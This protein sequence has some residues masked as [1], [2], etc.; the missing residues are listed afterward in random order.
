M[1]LL[2]AIIYLAFISLGLPDSLLGS[3]WPVISKDLNIGLAFAGVIS[4]VV[5]AGT[6]VSSLLST[7]V[8]HRFGT[9]IVIVIS[10]AMTAFALYGFTFAQNVWV[11]VILAIPLGLGAGAV[12]AALNNFVA[13]HYKS[14]HMNYL[15]SFW[16]VGATSGPL[17]MAMYLSQQE[18]WRDGYATISYIQ[19]ALVLILFLALPLWKIATN[20][21]QT[22]DGERPHFVSNAMGLRIKGV[23]FQ[24]L[25]FFCYCSLEAATGLWAASFLILEHGVTPSNAAF[26]TAMYFLGI[27][28]G[29]FSC[30]FIADSIDEKKMISVGVVL[31]FIGVILLLMPLSAISAKFG[32]I[33]IGLGCAPIYPNTIH[34]T[35][36]R[37]GK[38]ASQ[39]IIGLSMACAYLGTTLMPPLIGFIAV[40]TSFMMLPFALLIFTALML[41]TTQRLKKIGKDTL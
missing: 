18:G 33:I 22:T 31:I 20:N 23:K 26:W 6:V 4:I 2:L 30:G 17:I 19:I 15:H 37:F 14:K 41:F 13:T 32:L 21:N 5:S 11:F 24:L 25:M 38:H 1:L 3:S 34:L 36:S 35:P 10:V 29:R 9:G 8:I 40:S 12:D 16:G 39:A 27:T 7:R 28:L